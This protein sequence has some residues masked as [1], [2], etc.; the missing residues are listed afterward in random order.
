MPRPLCFMIMPYGTK[1][2]QAEAGRG[3]AE[4]DFNAL[5]D[6]AF[7][8]AIDQLG[9]EPVR[10]D[11]DTG[12][13]IVTQMIERI[14]FADLVLADMT[15]PNGNVYYEVGVRHAAQKRGCV[16][17]AADWSKRLFD[18]AQLRT[19]TYPL[20]DGT[21]GVDAAKAVIA[22]IK[23]PVRALSRGLSPVHDA[24]KGYPDD[25]DEA[26][27]STMKE[28]ML[29]LASFQAQIRGVRALPRAQRMAAAKTLAETNLGPPV[30]A[31][32][33]LGL[34]RLLKD[35]AGV[36]DDWGWI[37]G[38]IGG[39]PPEI[40]EVEEVREL[41]AFALGNGGKPTEAIGKLLTLIAMS[42]PSP[43]RYG[44]LGGRYK[45]LSDAAVAANDLGGAASFLS[46]SIDAYENGMQIDLNEYYCSSNLPRLYRKRNRKGD[47]ERAS[48]VSQLVVAACARAM[49]LGKAD[50]WLRPT[51]LGAAFDAGNCDEA[52]QLADQIADEGAA[53]WKLDAML[54]DLK[55]SAA[56]TADPACRDR[57]AAVVER[58]ARAG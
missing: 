17:L 56:L 28:R 55:T 47:S 29:E 43:E 21:V 35:C 5:W 20:T 48:A 31:V 40:A 15:I 16:L 44:M 7:A 18:V 32:T 24:I 45:R 1:S 41:E 12:A 57:L 13:L 36:A 38:A 11:Q 3:V 10:A 49:K 54:A 39:L 8:P 14:Y 27:A 58:L 52:E 4:I 19:V 2:T 53:R 34:L 25:V 46:K 6:R 9:Y 23:E 33:A 30:T 37:S 26:T 22:A 42:G 51:L 50:E